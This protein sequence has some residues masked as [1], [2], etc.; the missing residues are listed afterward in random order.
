ML[1][2]DLKSLAQK[3]AQEMGLSFGE[4]IRIA[5]T[6][7]LSEAP[8]T[9][10]EDPLLADHAVYTGEAPADL[11]ARHDDYLYGEKG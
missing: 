11:A 5:L 9:R 10:K 7:V 6:E 1:P 2:P 8:P 3:R 4:L